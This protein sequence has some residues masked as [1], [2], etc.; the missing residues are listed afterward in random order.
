MNPVSNSTLHLRR[1][2]VWEALDSGILLWRSN[3]AFFLPFFAIP[4]WIVAFL[5]RL[6]P[7]NLVYLSYL[8]VWWLKPLFDRLVLH[9]VSTRFFSSPAAPQFSLI[10]RGLLG[11]LSWRRFSLNRAAC[12]PLRVL[13]NLDSR[14]FQERK[15]SLATGGLAY[16]P[17]IS[18]L[19]LVLEMMLL[20]GEIMFFFM[21]GEILFPSASDYIWNDFENIEIFIFAAFCFNFIIVESLYMCMGFGLYINSRVEVEGWDLQLLFQK[22]AGKAAK[23]ILLICIFLAPLFTPLAANAEDL[24]PVPAASVES[25]NEILSSRDFGGEREG[26]GISLKNPRERREVPELELSSWMERLRQIFGALLRFFVIASIALFLSFSIFYLLKYHPPSFWR[27]AKFR[28][29]GRADPLLA[30]ESPESLFSRAEEFYSRGQLRQAWAACLAGNMGAYSRHYSVSF[31]A[32][33]TEYGCLKLLRELLSSLPVPAADEGFAELV[34][35]WV[36]FAYGGRLP[37]EGAFQRA[38]AHGRSI[39]EYNEP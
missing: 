34:G 28:A 8:I 32:D 11:D 1:R 14:Q 23:T 21:L 31:P 3:F 22:F 7:G 17:L 27:R 12:M 36:F 18:V 6:L 25:L 16:C 24:P 20:L 39:G 10:W 35:S 19:G 29:A 2:S 37:A 33:A 26:W 38:L 30:A 4:V 5:L 9:V 15:K 13:E